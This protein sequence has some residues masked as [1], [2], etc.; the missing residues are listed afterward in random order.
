LWKHYLKIA[1]R[2]LRRNKTFS[3][4]N[5]SGLAIGIA[6]CLL[7]LIFV[8][9]ELSYDRY[10]RNGERILMKPRPS[11]SAGRILWGKPS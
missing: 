8:T 10:H 3:L 9:D 5:I 6:G 1:T 4:I 11:A 7:I 2:N